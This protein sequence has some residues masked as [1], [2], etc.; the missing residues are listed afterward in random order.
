MKLH[1]QEDRL[2]KNSGLLGIADS[3]TNL[4]LINILLAI[5]NEILGRPYFLP[6]NNKCSQQPLEMWSQLNLCPDHFGKTNR[7]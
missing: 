6:P 1:L 5:W 4:L 3:T 7:V 2:I